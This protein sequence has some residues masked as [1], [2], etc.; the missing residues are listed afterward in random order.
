[1]V[2]KVYDKISNGKN[3]RS[4]RSQKSL[5]GFGWDENQDDVEFEKTQ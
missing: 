5:I 3:F 1:M 2:K 4:P